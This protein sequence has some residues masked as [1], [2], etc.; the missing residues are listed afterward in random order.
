MNKNED[1]I[2]GHIHIFD[3]LCVCDEYVGN[4][5]IQKIINKY[6]KPI[7]FILNILSIT[8][9]QRLAKYAGFIKN[10][11]KSMIDNLNSI[12]KSYPDNTIYTV[13]TINME[14]MNAGNVPKSYKDQLSEAIDIKKT[15]DD[16]L[17]YY[18][19]VPEMDYCNSLLMDNIDHIKGVKIYTLMGHFPYHPTLMDT[20]ELCDIYGFSV[21]SHCAPVNPTHNRN[22]NY[23]KDQLKFNRF[24]NIPGS[25][26]NLSHMCSN[27]A[28]PVHLSWTSKNYPNV[29]FCASHMGGLDELRK[30]IDNNEIR[31]LNG[32]KICL[33]DI[34]LYDLSW[35]FWVLYYCIHI[36]NFYTDISFT[37]HNDEFQQF[38]K[39]L[40]NHP[41]LRTKI[42]FGSDFYMNKAKILDENIFYEILI[43]NI[44]VENF[45][46]IAI[47]NQM[48]FYKNL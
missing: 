31:Y 15:N 39:I 35:T 33:C 1:I 32:T 22:I 19:A 29:N 11:N 12:K 48:K 28:H 24:Y 36:P 26:K 10:N 6:P 8:N 5:F 27:F 44:G 40:L 38:L 46:Q 43:K 17:I 41:I 42:L 3:Q 20:Y 47:I 13:L 45:E 2:N 14:G 4:K 18:H 23:V 21:I 16:I 9:K 30:F 37:F 25:D 7:I 34:G